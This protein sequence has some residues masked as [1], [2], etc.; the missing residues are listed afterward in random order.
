MS[1]GS[2]WAQPSGAGPTAHGL[3]K[4]LNPLPLRDLHSLRHAERCIEGGD[5]GCRDGQSGIVCEGAWRARRDP[6]IDFFDAGSTKSEKIRLL[7][8]AT[9]AKSIPGPKPAGKSTGNKAMA[10]SDL[11]ANLKLWFT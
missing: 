10:E 6:R 1:R 5:E 4:H 11:L 2:Y 9:L 3:R 7:E 8:G